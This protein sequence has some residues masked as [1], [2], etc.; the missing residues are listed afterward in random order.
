MRT[1]NTSGGR[2][3]L[4][5]A[6]GL[7]S[8]QVIAM[9]AAFLANVVVAR[10]LGAEEFG[11]FMFL[12]AVL[13]Y[14]GLFF[15]GGTSIA[16]GRLLA[17]SQ[18]VP[19]QRRLVGEWL[20]LFG[21]LGL[22][23]AGTLLLSAVWIDRIFQFQ[24]GEALALCALPAV[25]FLWQNALREILQGLGARM[26]L[27]VLHVAPWGGFLLGLGTLWL[28]GEASLLNVGLVMTASFFFTGAVLALTLRPQLSL[29]RLRDSELW[30][31]TKRFG[32]HA[33][34]G[35]L[36]GTGTYQLDTPLIAFFT[37]DP[38]SVAFYGLAKGMAAP[39]VLLT[40]SMGVAS[41]RQLAAAQRLPRGLVWWGVLL[42]LAACLAVLFVGRPVVLGLLS[43]KY[44]GVLPLLY[45]WVGV[46]FIQGSY[47]LPNLFLT[48]QG[49]GKVLLN[50]ALWFAFA[51]LVLNFSLIPLWGAMGATLAS[52]GAY[53]LWLLLCLF[54]YN[55]VTGARV[56]VADIANRRAS[57]QL[58]D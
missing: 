2:T 22:A 38:I 21:V 23:Y 1:V 40:R 16:A 43:E 55:R 52:G 46:A 20:A 8:A 53:L 54:Y 19:E 35:R 3:L 9:G 42:Q 47:Q 44:A 26:R 5:P 31:E 45:V 17:L 27:S 41:Y 25:G 4:L 33:F 56:E 58:H 10:L 50:M 48:A 51:N 37:R 6:G 34:L 15:D 13:T 14:V 29:P 30:T 36:A 39:I 24:V 11:R 49:Q 57:P 18:K 12:Y 7:F 32:F 28:A